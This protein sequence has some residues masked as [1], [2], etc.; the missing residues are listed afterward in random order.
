VSHHHGPDLTKSYSQSGVRLDC[1]SAMNKGLQNEHTLPAII[2]LVLI[3]SL[4]ATAFSADRASRMDAKGHVEQGH[5][6][7]QISWA[8]TSSQGLHN[9]EAAI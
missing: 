8:R 1:R 9:E 4:A 6:S 3:Q 5:C 7:V 2:C